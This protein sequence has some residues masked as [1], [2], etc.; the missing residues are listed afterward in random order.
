M[1]QAG[2]G[3]YTGGM[4]S[5]VPYMLQIMN[6]QLPVSE[7]DRATFV[8]LTCNTAATACMFAYFG[9]TV[10]ASDL[11]ARGT[12]AASALLVNQ[13]LS[14]AA[15]R[16]LVNSPHAAMSLHPLTSLEHVKGTLPDDVL[17]FIDVIFHAHDIGAVGSSHANLMR[18]L[19]IRLYVHMKR[20]KAQS[21]DPVT[22]TEAR[23]FIIND[24]QAV[25]GLQ[26]VCRQKMHTVLRGDCTLLVNSLHDLKGF[27]VAS[28]NPPTNGQGMFDAHHRAID[29]LAGR[30]PFT[31]FPELAPAP[32]NEDNVSFWTRLVSAQ[33]ASLPK[34][35]L[36]MNLSDS[37]D[38]TW[39]HCQSVFSGYG[40]LKA[41][42]VLDKRGM[43]RLSIWELR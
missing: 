36:A 7:W 6:A 26:K 40:E 18:Y 29:A 21:V 11:A 10:V 38:I 3:P 34:G 4:R 30:G 33:L 14:K 16:E 1:I 8:D 2:A 28:V 27:V 24:L 37:G 13:T 19:A 35:T 32:E 39:D 5:S 20:S 42:N 31:V 17:N 41:Q 25:S 43:T 23:Q 15:L 12:I 9:A 22:V